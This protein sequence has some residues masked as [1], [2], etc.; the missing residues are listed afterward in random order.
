[1]SVAKTDE[2]RPGER[3]IVEIGRKWIVIFNID[4]EYHAIADVCTHD[5]G[6]LAEGELVGCEIECPR[7]G[8]K[9]DVRTGKVLAPPALVDVPAYDVRVENDEILIARKSRS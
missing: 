2:L 5:D 3:M 6:P 7:H 8:A 4:G 9:F 1:M